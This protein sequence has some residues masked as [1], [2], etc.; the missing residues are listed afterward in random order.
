MYLFFK[1]SQLV[2]IY[3]NII[4]SS[5]ILGVIIYNAITSPDKLI[6]VIYPYLVFELIWA[7]AF[8]HFRYVFQKKWL[9]MRVEVTQLDMPKTLP[10]KIDMQN[11]RLSYLGDTYKYNKQSIHQKLIKEKDTEF[12]Y[13]YPVLEKIHYKNE[14]RIMAVYLEWA[15]VKDS[16]N[17]S[18]LTHLQ[19]L[20]PIK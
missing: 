15:I 1:R 19:N 10:E 17:K 16:S 6:N 13:L 8:Y 4:V 18:Y 5:L 2:L 11:I 14:Y 7:I 12:A 20:V 3:L 9:F